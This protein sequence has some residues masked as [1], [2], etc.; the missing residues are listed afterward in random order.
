MPTLNYTTP[1]Y[2]FN[3]SSLTYTAT[4]ECYLCGLYSQGNAGDTIK[5]N[6]TNLVRMGSYLSTTYISPIKLSAGDVVT[7]SGIS[8]GFE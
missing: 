3:T 8:S 1:L 5:I 4:D 6:D 2:T 7:I